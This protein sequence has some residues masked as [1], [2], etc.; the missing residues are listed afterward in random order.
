MYAAPRN[1]HALVL[2]YQRPQSLRQPRSQGFGHQL[3]EDVNEVD[4]V[5]ILQGEASG[6]LGNHINKA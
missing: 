3:G 6:L 2:L 5:L 1:E 4:G